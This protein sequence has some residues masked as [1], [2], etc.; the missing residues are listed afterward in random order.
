MKQKID[1]LKLYAKGSANGW[2]EFLTDCL[3]KQDI[4]RL[5]KIRRELQAGM[6][7]LAKMKLNNEEI[8]V[9]FLRLCKSTENTAKQI[10]RLKHAMPGDN[11]LIA[12]KYPDRL[13]AKR[14]RDRELQDFL[15][16]SSY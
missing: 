13:S 1:L 10:I 6:A 16:R 15:R 12:S 9:W 3:N 7:D 5:A 8:N 4:N 11:P 2:N 14:A